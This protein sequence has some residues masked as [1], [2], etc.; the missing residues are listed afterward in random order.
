MALKQQNNINF[1][2]RCQSCVWNLK[3]NMKIEK[4]YSESTLM[5][6]TKKELVEYIKCIVNNNNVLQDMLDRQYKNY[7]E[8]INDIRRDNQ[9]S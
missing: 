8:K 3:K 4:E 6:M 5:R 9:D 2:T 7:M 1:H